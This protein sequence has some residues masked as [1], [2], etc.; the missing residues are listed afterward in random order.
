MNAAITPVKSD[1]PMKYEAPKITEIGTM[2]ELTAGPH[3][4]AI[5][6]HIQGAPPLGS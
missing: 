6:D 1:G 2:A 3:K 4:V 5:V